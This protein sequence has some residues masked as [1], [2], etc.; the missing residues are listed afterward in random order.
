M[1]KKISFVVLIA[2]AALPCGAFMDRDP[3]WGNFP[4]TMGGTAYSSV[5]VNQTKTH[6]TLRFMLPGFK[7]KDVDVSLSENNFLTVKAHHKR[8]EI[9]DE[10]SSYESMKSEKNYQQSFRLPWDVEASSIEASM[11]DGVLA[12]T[13]KKKSEEKENSRKIKIK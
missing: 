4:V 9:R 5:E 3:F 13:M 11:E 1:L 8:K 2:G 10:K 7:K 6:I 12:V